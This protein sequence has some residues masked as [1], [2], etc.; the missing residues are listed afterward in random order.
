MSEVTD[1]PQATEHQFQAEV[2]EV[3]SLVINSLYSNKEIFLR[4][5]LSNASDALDKQ[6]FAM[7]TSP[8]AGSPD[9]LEIRITLD[10]DAGTIAIADNGIGMTEEE[11]V[12]NLGTIAHSGSRQFIEKLKESKDINLIG[13]F[14][15]GFYSAY[16][17]ADKVT[18]LSRSAD[19]E[20]AHQ[21]YSD[22][23][24]SF[25]VSPASRFERGT[26]IILHL[27]DEHKEYATSW[28]I[29]ELVRR[30]SDYIGYPIKLQVEKPVDTGDDADEG[31]EVKTEKTWEAINQARAL[32]QRSPKDI[33]DEQYEEFFKHLTHDW[34]GPLAHK[35][36]KIEGTYLFSGL[37][38][39][40]KR[41]PF[42]LFSADTKYG[43]RLHVKRV[44]IM[45]EC[46]DLLPRWLRFVRGVI[47]SDDLPLNVS[48]ELLQ[49]SRV[50]KTIRKQVIK[51]TL[52]MLGK[53]ADDKD[54]YATFWNNYGEIIKEG[55]HFQPE[56]KQRLAKLV[57]YA[58]SKG[59]AGETDLVSLDEYID[60][61]PEDQPAVYY[62][63]GAA[64]EV[65]AAS[66]HLEAIK[67]KGYEI[68]YMT[69]AVDQW[70]VSGLDDYRD[71]KFVSAMTADLDLGDKDKDADE[72]E[73]KD[74]DADKSAADA[75]EYSDLMAHIR[76]VLQEKVEKV[77]V[78]ERLTGS[79]ACLVV[80]EG[81]LQPHIERL[82]RAQKAD[83]PESKRIL[84]INPRHQLIR[85]LRAMHERDAKSEDLRGWIELLYAQTLL[86]EGSPIDNPVAMAGRLT[87]L[88]QAAASAAVGADVDADTATDADADAEAAADAD[89]AADAEATADTAA[90]AEAAADTAADTD[91][92]G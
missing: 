57:R 83:I 55:L 48:R 44:L 45:D 89:T 47:D 27:K 87:S 58:S 63:L 77:R 76:S 34:E 4:E 62:A 6:R 32:W 37:L 35:H 5:L 74:A 86:A 30:Y 22:A 79:P 18:V 64:R 49:D 15:V 12:R 46:E 92:G 78:S 7:V 3:L 20:Q 33:T 19:S 10:E 65:V 42:G 66:P 1:K 21:W 85:N 14:G 59:G 60:R 39:V 71:K 53:L 43:V 88:L 80:P 56:H 52:D 51:Q 54:K 29:R 2:S 31:A 11:L 67:A 90:D 17:V 24:K 41:P 70:A 72:A 13:Q 91:A 61:M 40:P 38:F 8:D 28:R 82:L 81:G 50:T 73:D 16:L 36:F 69:D 68:L 26:T 75:A 9:D 23:K 25:T 84:E